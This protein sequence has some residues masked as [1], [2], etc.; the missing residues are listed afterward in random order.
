M[1]TAKTKAPA[2][3]KGASQHKAPDFS[4]GRGRP[5]LASKG[6]APKRQYKRSVGDD[7]LALRR[8]GE[9]MFGRNWK[10]DFSAAVRYDS[11]LITRVLV[12][13]RP[14]PE[15]MAKRIKTA[16]TEQRQRVTEAAKSPLLVVGKEVTEVALT[17]AN[18]K[19]FEAIGRAVWGT[20]FKRDLA[21]AV[22]LD[23]GL[24]TNALNGKRAASFDPRA[25]KAAIK[26]RADALASL[27]NDPYLS[28]AKT[29]APASAE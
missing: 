8:L 15:D 19:A 3:K 29:S 12:G 28:A 27:R 7:V 25:L 11:G 22:S 26:E 10:V 14:V 23:P 6:L 21:G 2:S 24:M 16:L 5:P 1:T 18:A 20:Y 13:T 17:P 9:A 4:K